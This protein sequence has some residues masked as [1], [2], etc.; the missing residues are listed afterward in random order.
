MRQSRR[1]LPVA[2]IWSSL[3][4]LCLFGRSVAAADAV[5]A[6]RATQRI[7]LEI[8]GRVQGVGFRDFTQRAARQLSIA[9]WVRNI[10]NGRVELVAEGKEAAIQKFQ[11]QIKKGP[12]G[13]RVDGVKT[14]TVDDAEKFKDFDIKES[15]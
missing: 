4:A 14:L 2:L 6:E 8:S 13:A 11:E 12:L 5:D 10:P 9:G 7:H 3:V 1:H 15:L